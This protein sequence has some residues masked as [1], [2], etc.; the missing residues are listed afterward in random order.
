MAASQGI[1]GSVGSQMRMVAQIQA[2]S[3]PLNSIQLGLGCIT[4]WPVCALVKDNTILETTIT[5]DLTTV[6]HGSQ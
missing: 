3:V 1:E 6:G 5:S 2:A 4:T